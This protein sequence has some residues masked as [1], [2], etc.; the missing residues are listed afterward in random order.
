MQGRN[1][2]H[3]AGAP[4]LRLAKLLALALLTAGVAPVQASQAEPKGQRLAALMQDLVERLELPPM[5]TG[6]R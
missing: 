5:A 3:S 1:Y 4:R 2:Q 6:A